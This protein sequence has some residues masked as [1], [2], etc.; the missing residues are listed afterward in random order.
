MMMGRNVSKQNTSESENRTGWK[1]RESIA[2]DSM[3]A[4]FLNPS[5]IL[6]GVSFKHALVTSTF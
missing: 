1:S 6:L 2:W 5:H 3:D 4:V